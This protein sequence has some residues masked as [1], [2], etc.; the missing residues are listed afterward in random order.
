M[1][2]YRTVKIEKLVHDTIVH[3]YIKI[4]E[5]EMEVSKDRR[6]ISEYNDN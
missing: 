1:N 5:K 4:K 6:A 2:V 3:M